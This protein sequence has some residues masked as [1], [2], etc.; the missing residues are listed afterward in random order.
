MTTV[1]E[2]M[3]VEV[4]RQ[5]NVIRIAGVTLAQAGDA[6]SVPHALK[7]LEFL[8]GIGKSTAWCLALLQFDGVL[9]AEELNA[10]AAGTKVA[11]N[12]VAKSAAE[13]W[14]ARG[15]HCVATE[16]EQRRLHASWQKLRLHPYHC[17]RCIHS[18]CAP[19]A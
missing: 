9:D 3:L 2:Q 7:F 14:L 13:K 18:F 4:A 15:L 5:A 10:V 1:Q 17:R 12:A 8:E 11:A 19:G 6:E 16:T